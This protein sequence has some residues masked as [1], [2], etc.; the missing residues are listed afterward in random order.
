MDKIAE[1]TKNFR[2]D[3][4]K[5]KSIMERMESEFDKGLDPRTQSSSTT[6][7]YPT[8]VR[9]VP[10][11]KEH[12][13]FIALDLGGTNFR[14]LLV[15]L[16]G[17]RADPTGRIFGISKQ[18]ME[19][20]GDMLFDHIARCLD[21]FLRQ[22]K[23]EIRSS[24]EQLQFKPI[25]VGFTFSF[26]CKQVGLEKAILTRWGKGFRCSG[27]VG[28][29]I[30]ELLRQAI[31]RRNLPVEVTAVVNDTTGT[32]M[33]CAFTDTDCRIGVIC[34]TGTNACYMEKLE[35]IKTLLEE[36]GEMIINTEW[37]AFG[38][39]GLLN[40]I[41]TDFDAQLD[42][43]SINAR[44]QI[45]EKMCSGMYLGEL[46]RLV[47]LK[48][49]R[50]RILFRGQST[51]LLEKKDQIDAKFLSLVEQDLTAELRDYEL[52]QNHVTQLQNSDYESTKKALREIGVFDATEEDFRI[53]RKI[54]QDISRRSAYLVAAG[55]SVMLL[56]IPFRKMTAVGVDGSVFRKHPAFSRRVNEKIED[57]VGPSVGFRLVLSSDGSGKGAA[58][59]AAVAAEKKLHHK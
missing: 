27:V 15:T 50:E 57:L 30:T 55:I 32:F 29:D 31:R 37:G 47:M 12:G 7:M 3:N 23:K 39:G 26:A 16:N 59:I 41:V 17:M 2:L 13:Q 53:V 45:Y 21:T 46:A 42:R 19:G 10:H 35:K 4:D 28:K 48:A 54:C 49:V 43:N 33:S 20:T 14:I 11:G 51:A 56:R 5:L 18:I 40:D 1:L 25:P 8:F 38:E 58:V 22:F 6:K 52:N 24:Q 34:G 9:S 44:Y 36:K